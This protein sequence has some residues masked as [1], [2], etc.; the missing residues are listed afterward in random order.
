MFRVTPLLLAFVVVWFSSGFSS[1]ADP[2]A[3]TLKGLELC[4]Q[5][6][7]GQAVFVGA[8]S[9]KVDGH[10][11]FGYWWVAA[12]HG[13]DPA[14]G[15][16]G[17]LPEET[18]GMTNIVGTWSLE[19]YVLRGFAFRHESFGGGLAGKLT[20][21]GD[22]DRPVDN[23]DVAATLFDGP[24]TYVVD[25]VLYHDRFPPVLSLTIQPGPGI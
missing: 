5:E 2:V 11:A 13:P 22:N 6:I 16:L 1:A 23:F 12:N 9:G 18:G 20:N 7:C 17:P 10:F 25:G 14:N 4:T 19:V 8:F 21:R 24:S 15:Q 3:G